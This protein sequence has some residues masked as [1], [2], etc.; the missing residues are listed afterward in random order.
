MNY[1][2]RL[3]SFDTLFPDEKLQIPIGEICQ[4]SELSV[5]KGGQIL[6]HTQYCDEI[7]YAISGSAR[8]MSGDNWTEM[9][10]GQIHFI[11][12]GVVHRIMVNKGEN[13]RFVCLGFCL[14]DCEI[15]SSIN[16][17]MKDKTHFMISDNKS[18]KSLC[19]LV[20]REFHEWD[21]QSGDSVNRYLSQIIVNMCR[22][23]VGNMGSTK[24]I[25][26]DKRTANLSFYRVLQYIDRE[27]VNIKTVKGV[28]ESLAYSEYYLSHIFKEKMNMGV[29][30]YIMRKKIE[31]AKEL[32]KTTHLTIEEISSY[33]NFSSSHSFRRAYKQVVGQLP[34]ESRNG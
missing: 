31:K 18:V 24:G 7:T 21:E 33:L 34:N 16:S 26:Y 1:S 3:F 10:A 8:V 2:D 25:I 23:L 22:I 9:R 20:I 27:Y 4:V 30:E 32:L 19:E 29:K 15:A 5:V 13:F 11:K 17:I 12:K 14:N 28:A 6:R